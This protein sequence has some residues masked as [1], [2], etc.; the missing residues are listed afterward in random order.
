[1]VDTIKLRAHMHKLQPVLDDHTIVKVLHGS[2]YDVE[3]LQKDFN[4][5]L[6]HMFDTG[7][8]ARVLSLKSFSLAHLLQHYCLVIADKK[9][10][11]ADWRQRPLPLEM[12]KYA[13]EDTHYLLYCYD[14]L[15]LELIEKG[16]K[17]NSA[18]PFALLRAVYQ[19]SLALC[20]KQYEKPQV[21]DYNY[22]MIVARN[23]TL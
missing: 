1:M 16:T 7:Q 23:K 10:Q 21:K 6:V 11:T 5:Y 22:F 14:M 19:K 8:A 4:L 20:M 9:Y 15:R 3:W 2:D 12:I 18:N 17:Q 13:R